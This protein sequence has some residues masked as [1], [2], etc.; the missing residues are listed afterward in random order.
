MCVVWGYLGKVTSKVL[1]YRH[2]WWWREGHNDIRSPCIE[3]YKN[4]NYEIRKYVLQNVYKM[5][6]YKMSKYLGQVM[7]TE[8]RR[9]V[10][11]W[12]V[13]CTVQGR[14]GKYEVLTPKVLHKEATGNFG[15]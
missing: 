4:M 15:R 11:R 12:I 2:I 5:Q 10:M 14:I 3:K 13:H 8:E 6:K 9:V 7:F 1:L